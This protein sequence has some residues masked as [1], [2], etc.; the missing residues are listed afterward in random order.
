MI[1]TA[2]SHAAADGAPDG[3]LVSRFSIALVSSVLVGMS[4][5]DPL[6]EPLE[7][8]SGSAGAIGLLFYGY[9][10][11]VIR[12]ERARQ[13]DATKT[14]VE[15]RLDTFIAEPPLLPTPHTVREWSPSSSGSYSVQ[16]ISR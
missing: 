13:A 7:L 4:L 6:P 11:R 1:S 2:S 3:P 14:L 5:G 9:R 15:R 8:L 12:I 16:R 10:S